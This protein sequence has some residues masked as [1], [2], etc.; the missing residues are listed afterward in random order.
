MQVVNVGEEENGE[1]K[2]KAIPFQF[3]WLGGQTQWTHSHKARRKDV[4]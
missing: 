4:E 3:H 2:E 1:E